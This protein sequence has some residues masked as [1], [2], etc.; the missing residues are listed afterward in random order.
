[1]AK[2]NTLPLTWVIFTIALIIG[3]FLR[4]WNFDATM[5]FLGDQG[6]DALVA[7]QILIDHR[8]VLIGPVTSTGNMY[9][10][11]FY[12]YFMVPFLALTYPSPLGPAYAVAVFAVIG[13]VLMYLMGKEMVGSRAAVI[14]T[15]FLALSSVAI[16][17]SRFSWN[18]NLAPFVSIIWLWSLYRM[19]KKNPWYFVLTTI[20]ISVLMQLHYVTLMTVPISGIFWLMSLWQTYKHHVSKPSSFILSSFISLLVFGLF[21]SP[22]VLFDVR[23][24]FLNLHALQTFVTGDSGGFHQEGSLMRV[25]QIM[26]ETHGRSLLILTEMYIGKFRALDSIIVII[27]LSC[28]TLWAFQKKQPNQLGYQILLVNVLI[29]AV[30]LAFY[31]STVF[32]HYIAFLYPVTCFIYGVM[33][34]KLLNYPWGKIIAAVFFIGFVTWNIIHMP[35]N[36][37]SWNVHNIQSAAET[38]EQRVK[39]GEKY[40]IV[41]LTGTGDIE[42]LNYRYFLDTSEKPPLDKTEWGTTDTL[43]IINEDKKLARVVDSPIYEIVVFPNKTPA[44][45]YT[46]PNGPEITVLRR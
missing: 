32:Y 29:S 30:G 26:N 40:N 17:F 3:V 41:L 28:L 34:D 35:F 27:I 12:Y 10:G 4:F 7:K 45:V 42:G 36:P 43:F 38:I 19:V 11:P 25:I 21:L 14:G 23:H 33:F 16:N 1:M 8:P 46:I 5:Q 22:L 18:P 9:L 2:L 15:L 20:C 24:D 31:Q 39:P 37:L 44:E 6:R 13:L